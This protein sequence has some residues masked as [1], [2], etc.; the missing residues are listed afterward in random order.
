MKSSVYYSLYMDHRMHLPLEKGRG[1][2][3]NMAFG[4]RLQMLRVGLSIRGEGV[5]WVGFSEGQGELN[6][7][8]G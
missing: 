4:T 3:K 7:Q 8:E 6:S 2:G 1:T 5:G